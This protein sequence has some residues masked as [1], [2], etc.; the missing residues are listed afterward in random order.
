M[1]TSQI[2]TAPKPASGG[3]DGSVYLSTLYLGDEEARAI[4]VAERFVSNGTLPAINVIDRAGRLMPLKKKDAG[5][6]S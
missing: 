2:D 6:G 3:V 1:I 5:L 4:E